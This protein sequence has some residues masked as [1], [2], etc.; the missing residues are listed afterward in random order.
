M[1]SVFSASLHSQ[2]GDV[3]NFSDGIYLFHDTHSETTRRQEGLRLQ[4]SNRPLSSEGSTELCDAFRCGVVQY[5]HTPFGDLQTPGLHSK[6]DPVFMHHDGN[7]V[8]PNISSL[9]NGLYYCLLQHTAGMTLWPYELHVGY[10]HQKNQ[11]HGQHKHGSGC[12]TFRFRRD[13]GSEEEKQAGVSDGQFAG[14]VA[15]SVLLTFVLGFSAGA[16]S[17]AHVLR[18]RQEKQE[19]TVKKW[20]HGRRRRSIAIPAY[21]RPGWSQGH[22]GLCLWPTRMANDTATF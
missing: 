17:R 22:S 6:L 5:W 2:L 9:H 11:E 12:D 15:A 16:L 19:D 7:L 13:V 8:A 4:R 3:R 18:D 20:Y 14:A 1:M 21:A 10:E